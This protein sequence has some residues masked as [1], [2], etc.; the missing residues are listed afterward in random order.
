MS[1]WQTY[2]RLSSNA[3]LKVGVGLVAWGLLGL[4][5]APKAEEKL[6]YTPTEA[7]KEALERMTP[8]IHTVPRGERP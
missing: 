5:F 6:G 4:Q 7:D 3:K 8:K 2:R 1:L